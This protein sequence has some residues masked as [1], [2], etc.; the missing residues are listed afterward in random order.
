MPNGQC[1]FYEDLPRNILQ[2][3]LNRFE[4]FFNVDK[5]EYLVYISD[6]NAGPKYQ[7]PKP[8]MTGDNLKINCS[9]TSI[10]QAYTIQLKETRLESGQGSCTEYPDAAGHQSYP[11]CIDD[12]NKRKGCERFNSFEHFIFLLNL[13]KNY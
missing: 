10:T 6:P 2:T 13:L 12:E 11:D 1:K 3:G 9:P 5:G 7:L 4:I 8:D